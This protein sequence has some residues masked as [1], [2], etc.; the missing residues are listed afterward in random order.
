QAKKFPNFH[1]LMQTEAKSLVIENSVVKGLTAQAPSGQVEIR[2]GLT[3]AADGRH[4]TLRPEAGL[5]SQDIGAPIDVLWMRISRKHD[6]HA[7]PLGIVEQGHMFVMLDR[8]TYWQCA[9]VIPKGGIEKVKA[10]GLPALRQSILKLA[11][12]LENRVEEIKNW[13]DVK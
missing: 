11:P 8:S 1:L 12:F 4:S 5:E 6:D 9:Y 10:A 2:A 13:D 7:L 3:V